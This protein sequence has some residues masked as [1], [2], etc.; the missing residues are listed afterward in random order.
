MKR[1]EIWS[2]VRMRHQRS[3]VVVGSDEVTAKRDAVL[4]VPLSEVMSAA[5]E[6][7]AVAESSGRPMG[8]A[9]APRIGEIDKSYF[10]V[11][12]GELSRDSLDKLD[13]ALREVLD[14]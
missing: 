11:P 12:S 4:S 2:V 5:P 7:P 3:V 10:L 9:L 6:H 8:V 13:R 14:L 1:G